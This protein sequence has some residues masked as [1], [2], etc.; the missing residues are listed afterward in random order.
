MHEPGEPRSEGS[1]GPA[2]VRPPESLGAL[3]VG[4]KVGANIVNDEFTFISERHVGDAYRR[5]DFTNA[6]LDVK[7]MRGAGA[8]EM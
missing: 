1:N 7:M 2:D 8:F 6:P 5:D 4:E 3:H